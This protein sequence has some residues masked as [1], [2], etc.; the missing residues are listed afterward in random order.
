MIVRV[1]T[2]HVSYPTSALP[3]LDLRVSQGVE[4]A[5][6]TRPLCA[7]V[8]DGTEKVEVD[9]S[10]TVGALRSVIQAQFKVPDSDQTLSLDQNLV[11]D[12]AQWRNAGRA[13]AFYAKT[14]D[15]RLLLGA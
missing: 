5:H 15:R 11:R 1:R 12:V 8:R 3:C 6:L 9:D 7:R 2:R 14:T 10:A 13:C 4:L